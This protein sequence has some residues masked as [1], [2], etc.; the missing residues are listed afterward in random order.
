MEEIIKV[1]QDNMTVSGRD[2]HEALGIK[3]RFSLWAERQKAVFGEEIT[4]VGVPT[5]STITAEYR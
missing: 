5:R 4:T 3:E 2:L 1:N